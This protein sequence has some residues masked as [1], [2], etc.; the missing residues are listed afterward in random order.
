MLI[1]YHIFT[2]PHMVRHI[3]LHVLKFYMHYYI[4]PKLIFPLNNI[5]L[6][7]LH[8]DIFIPS[9]FNLTVWF[10]Q[11]LFFYSPIEHLAASY[12]PQY[13]ENLNKPHNSCLLVHIYKSYSKS[14]VLTLAWKHTQDFVRMYERSEIFLQY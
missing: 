12:F 14:L 5:F 9:L 11:N 13:N 1:F 7:F 8:E 2:Y 6:T 10:C 3:F 4:I